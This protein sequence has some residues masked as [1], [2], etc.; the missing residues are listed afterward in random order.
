MKKILISTS[1][2]DINNI[3]CKDLLMSHNFSFEFNKLNK[4][5]SEDE[6]ACLLE[7]E[8][9][10]VIAG[11]EPFTKNVLNNAKSLRVISRCGVGLDNIDLQE[12][13]K[14]GISVYNTPKAPVLSVAELTVAHILSLARQIVLSDRLI[15]M[16]CWEQKMGKLISEYVIG[17]VGYGNIGKKVVELLIPFGPKILIYDLKQIR[18]DKG[19][20]FVDF[21]FL[22]KKSDVITLH[23]P[24]NHATRHI[25]NEST[26]NLMKKTVY[27]IN[28]SRG[29]LI[30]ENALYVFLKNNRLSG[31]AL[32]CFESEP[33]R[34]P[35][36]TC[37]NIQLTPHIG[38]Y[39]NQARKSMEIEASY[40]LFLGLSEQGLL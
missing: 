38:S 20:D 32:D 34:G 25:I 31:A 21:E 33:Y 2:F 22:L 12:A 6:I 40:N 27:L 7:K 15:R 16:G 4:K 29:G 30:D 28:L 26:L 23:L 8:I 9:I 11:T 19:L 14:L 13:Q 18:L 37:E 36:L 5:L 24:L 39:A 1:R 3:E 17:V 10:G 35:L